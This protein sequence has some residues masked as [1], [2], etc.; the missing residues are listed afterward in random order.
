MPRAHSQTESPSGEIIADSAGEKTTGLIERAFLRAGFANIAANA[1][2]VARAEYPPQLNLA[3]TWEI[4]I[5]RSLA[6]RSPRNLRRR[7][8]AKRE[9]HAGRCR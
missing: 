9:S 7:F 3:A 8:A 5:A 2:T 1:V 4:S 6:R